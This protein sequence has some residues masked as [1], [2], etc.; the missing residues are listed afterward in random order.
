[1]TEH[2]PCNE[3]IA[4]FID[5]HFDKPGAVVSFPGKMLN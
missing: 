4:V 1:M 5:F 3:I 2:M